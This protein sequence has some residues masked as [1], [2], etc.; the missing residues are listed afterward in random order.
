M[1]TPTTRRHHIVT[2]GLLALSAALLGLA[3]LPGCGSPKHLDPPL[4]TYP[5]D[6]MTRLSAE[7]RAKDIGGTVYHVADTH[8]MEPL[9]VGGDYIVAAPPSRAPYADLKAGTPIVYRAQWYT[10]H[11]VTHRTRVKD[12]YGWVVSGDN[13]RPDIAPNGQDRHSEASYR[14]TTESYLGTVDG[15]YRIKP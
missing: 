15:I 3:A 1:T 7:A 12:G 8:S 13:V 4:F 2:L 11:P 10:K 9:L 5:T 14:V 6:L